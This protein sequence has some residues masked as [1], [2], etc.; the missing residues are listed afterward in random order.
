MNRILIAAAA[1]MAVSVATP[2]L[3]HGHGP[4]GAPAVHRLHHPH[5]HPVGLPV[6]G[7]GHGHR[8]GHGHG[9][10]LGRVVHHGQSS[11]KRQH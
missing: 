2:A 6:H 5:R 8:G 4:V 3:A 1:L 9:H 10:V 11:G 7:H